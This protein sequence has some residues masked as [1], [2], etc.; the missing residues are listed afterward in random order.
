MKKEHEESGGLRNLPVT[1]M[2][3]MA[4]EEYLSEHGA[5]IGVHVKSRA[6]VSFKGEQ[7]NG[8]W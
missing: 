1:T 2:P 3:L 4:H 5:C 8:A 7:R 6:E